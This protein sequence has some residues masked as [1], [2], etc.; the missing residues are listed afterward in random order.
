MSE[1]IVSRQ[2][3][4][5]TW[6]LNRPEVRNALDPALIDA[7]TH[8]L[9]GEERRGTDVVVLRGEG[10]SFCAGADLKFLKTHDIGRGQ[11]PRAFLSSVWDLTLAMEHSDVTFV[12]AL[13]GHAIAGGMELALASDVVVAATGTLI[14][15]GHVR[16][17]LMPG[18]GASVRME[19]AIGRGASAWLA[20]SGSFLTAED[21]RLAGW[22]HEVVPAD[23]L[24][25]ATDRIVGQLLQVP[26]SARSRYKRLLNSGQRAPT[27]VDRDRELDAFDHHWAEQ[28]VPAALRSFLEGNR[29]PS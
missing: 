10:P 24:S 6:T 1:L 18:G 20:L 28:D 16:N 19:R 8:A 27:T 29:R 26:R 21:H 4:T 25:R 14:G 7:L 17:N 13:H 11:T 9:S 15:D 12:T 23:E 2:E 22:L 3:R 5:A